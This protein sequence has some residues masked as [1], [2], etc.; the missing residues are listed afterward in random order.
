MGDHTTRTCH[1][2]SAGVRQY[3]QARSRAEQG[4]Q[5]HWWPHGRAACVFGLVKH[6]IHVVS[7]PIVD[8]GASRRPVSKVAAA[9]ESGEDLRVRRC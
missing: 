1:Q 6:T 4:A 9:S 3:G 8:S 7:P 2:R 5:T